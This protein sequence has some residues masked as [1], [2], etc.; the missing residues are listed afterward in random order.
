[1]KVG[2]NGRHIE[3]AVTLRKKNQVTIPEAI[4]ERLGAKP[5]DQLMMEIDEATPG[6]ARVRRLLRSYAGMLKGVYGTPEEAAE[7]LRRERA[8]WGE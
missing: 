4:A 1:M 8:S 3:A 6:E 5:G 2:R 7:Y